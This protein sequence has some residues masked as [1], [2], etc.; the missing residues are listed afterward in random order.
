MTTHKLRA[1]IAALAAA[2]CAA[3][4]VAPAQASSGTLTNGI[5][6]YALY[7]PG[8]Y[9]GNNGSMEIILSGRPRVWGDYVATK[10]NV[11]DPGSQGNQFERND[12]GGHDY[13][14]GDPGRTFIIQ[15]CR[16]FWYG[17]HCGPW[18]SLTIPWW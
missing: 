8:S 17:S 10:Y 7:N 3:V 12:Y 1:T 15:G 5:S 18:A 6:Y 16:E 11:R 9:A 14:F 4:A 2:L 13:F